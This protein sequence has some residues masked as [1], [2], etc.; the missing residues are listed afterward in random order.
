MIAADPDSLPV[1][2]RACR[3]AAGPAPVESHGQELA[4]THR[5]HGRQVSGAQHPQLGRARA[6]VVQGDKHVAVVLARALAR[7]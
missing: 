7:S 4:Q 1:G 5:R 3:A 6:H 2:H